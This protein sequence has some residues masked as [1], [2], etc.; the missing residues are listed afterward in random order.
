VINRI[1]RAH[2]VLHISASVLRLVCASQHQQTEN[3]GNV[4]ST[5]NFHVN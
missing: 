5:S 1:P 4:Q 3:A 2:S